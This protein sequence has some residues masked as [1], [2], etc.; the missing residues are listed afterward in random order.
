MIFPTRLLLLSCVAALL[1]GCAG[2]AVRD[3][4]ADRAAVQAARVAASM[5]GKPYRYGGRSPSGF[6]CSGLVHYSFHK[7]GVTVPRSTRQQAKAST[8]VTPRA[9]RPGDLLF[10]HQE[11]RKSSHVGIYLGNDRFVHAPSS[12]KHVRTDSLGDEYWQR[13]FASARRFPEL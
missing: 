13:N 1:V 9:L 12:G 4:D 5:V 10:F 11:G 8:A 7:A 3:S 6:D 2:H